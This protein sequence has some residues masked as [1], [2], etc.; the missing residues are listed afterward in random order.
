MRTDA[1]LYVKET[2]REVTDDH[3]LLEVG[4]DTEQI[5]NLKE[6][7]FVRISVVLHGN[8]NGMS[9]S[10]SNWRY[11]YGAMMYT[12]PGQE[13]YGKHVTDKRVHVPEGQQ[14][15]AMPGFA[16][17]DKMADITEGVSKNVDTQITKYV[18]QF[19][20][21][22]NGALNSLNWSAFIGVG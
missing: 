18:N 10:S 2:K 19:I 1:C 21:E 4:I 8:M 16:Q 3:I 15:R 9:M 20:R 12:K 6:D 5:K 11:S 13:T 7:L 17:G 14:P 22:V